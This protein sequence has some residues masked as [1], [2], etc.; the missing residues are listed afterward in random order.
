[1]LISWAVLVLHLEQFCHESAGKKSAVR[2][3]KSK[4]RSRG[5]E[6]TSS[7]SNQ[8]VCVGEGIA[9]AGQNSAV[10]RASCVIACALDVSQS[11]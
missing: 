6:S 5:L 8:D 9:Y 7:K 10:V 2:R 1:M 4:Q 3:R 11:F